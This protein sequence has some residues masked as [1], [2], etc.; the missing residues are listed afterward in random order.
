MSEKTRTSG[1]FWYGDSVIGRW[2]D[3]GK[4][5]GNQR[6]EGCAVNADGIT[7][8]GDVRRRK[9]KRALREDIVRDV[10]IDSV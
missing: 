8:R 9:K 7:R 6:F 4:E 5:H 10:L 2:R 3:H 1:K